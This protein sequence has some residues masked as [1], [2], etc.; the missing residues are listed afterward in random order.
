VRKKKRLNRLSERS[1]VKERALKISPRFQ[2]LNQKW[3]QLDVLARA[4][5]IGELLNEAGIGSQ[6]LLARLL[7]RHV[8][9]ESTIRLYFRVSKLEPEWK[10]EI[11]LGKPIRVV[12]RLQGQSQRSATARNSSKP[13]GVPA[14]PQ[15]V[16]PERGDELEK[17]FE[18]LQA[19]FRE[20]PV[21]L[22]SGAANSLMRSL[23]LRLEAGAKPDSKQAL[24]D[25]ELETRLL[26]WLSQFV[27]DPE[28]RLEVV[29]LAERRYRNSLV[30][31]G[32]LTPGPPYNP[33]KSRP[34]EAQERRMN[35]GRPKSFP[36][37]YK[38]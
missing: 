3:P 22:T 11:Q 20:Q 18:D 28:L 27:P 34:R 9:D 37:F 5:L 2:Q 1:E 16:S 32:W 36:T 13:V 14:P 31:P 35:E 30:Q 21:L 8:R 25:P 38:R 29:R 15:S 19:W 12:L 4:D 33:G 26:S 6:R 10:E 24:Y 23:R 7:K 17:V